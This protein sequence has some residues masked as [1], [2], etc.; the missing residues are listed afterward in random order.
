MLDILNN[1]PTVRDVCF[2]VQ[3]CM[4][5]TTG[6]LQFQTCIEVLV[7]HAISVY[8][9]HTSKPTGCLHLYYT[10]NNSSITKDALL[11]SKGA[12]QLQPT[13]YTVPYVHPC[14]VLLCANIHVSTRTSKHLHVQYV[15][16]LS[17]SSKD[18]NPPPVH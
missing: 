16:M 8:F 12:K 3:R 14:L 11:L 1:Q 9:E 18:Y 13:S 2:L 15:Y 5:A 17:F 10:P 4:S 7:Q 6:K